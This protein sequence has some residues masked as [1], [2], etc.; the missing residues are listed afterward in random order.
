[1][2][3][4]AADAVTTLRTLTEGTDRFLAAL[5][6]AE[7]RA[8]IDADLTE[9]RRVGEYLPTNDQR[10]AERKIREKHEKA[11][12]EWARVEATRFGIL[13]HDQPDYAAAVARYS[14]PP[15][16]VEAFERHSGR[17]GTS[18]QG[19]L[20]LLNLEAALAPQYLARLKSMTPSAVEKW[21][22]RVTS[23]AFEP[24]NA[25]A[26]PL[27]EELRDRWSGVDF[28][29]AREAAEAAALRRLQQKIGEV[30][31]ARVPDI[32]RQAADAITTATK[33][34]DKHTHIRKL[35]LVSRYE[36]ERAGS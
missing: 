31:A 10:T 24:R 5:D 11:H 19:Y 1:M 20:L 12:H 25:V 22:E 8:A 29:P 26:I 9:F 30:R 16:I 23:D 13:V 6:D 17:D 18:E 3:P 33:L 2:I 35:T 7:I 36:L 32:I 28:D 14:E 4:T 34:F 27:I 21:Y 15:G